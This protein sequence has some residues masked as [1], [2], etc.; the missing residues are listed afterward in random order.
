MVKE[1]VFVRNARD[2]LT[3]SQNAWGNALCE[4]TSPG[5][6]NALS[7]AINPT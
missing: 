1:K 5:A 6:R 7:I 2:F 3:M 4:K